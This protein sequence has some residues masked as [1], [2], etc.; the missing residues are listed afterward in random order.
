MAV[1]GL[2]LGGTKLVGAVFDANGAVLA[3]DGALLEGRGG[4]EVGSLIIAVGMVVD[5]SIVVIENIYRH[6]DLGE[7]RW[8]SARKGATEVGLAVVASTATSIAVFTPVFFM[9][10]GQM[11]IIMKAFAIPVAVSLTASRT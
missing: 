11:S 2:D 1:I 5:D 8:E 9:E 7:D 10:Q 4:G 3:E 6:Q